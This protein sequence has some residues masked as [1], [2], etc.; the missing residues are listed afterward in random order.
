ME[1]IIK[2]WETDE[3]LEDWNTA[4]ICHTYKQKKTAIVEYHS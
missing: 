2:V 3:I 4:M 1:I